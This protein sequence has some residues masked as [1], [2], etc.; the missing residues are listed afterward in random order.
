MEE[1]TERNDRRADEEQRRSFTTAVFDTTLAY[2]TPSDDSL[3]SLY[4]GMGIELDSAVAAS[5]EEK[6]RFWRRCRTPL[7]GIRIDSRQVRVR[8]I[9]LGHSQEKGDESSLSVFRK[10]GRPFLTRQ[11]EASLRTIEVR[12]PA[13][14]RTADG[15]RDVYSDVAFAWTW[16][17][18]SKKWVLTQTTTYNPRPLDDGEIVVVTHPN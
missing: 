16:N 9:Q 6:A 12:V 10:S 11:P 13:V 15:S 14:T 18:E 17:P 1:A 7:T 3:A 2:L 8:E 5:D 4:E